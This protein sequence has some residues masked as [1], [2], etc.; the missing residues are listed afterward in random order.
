MLFRYRFFIILR[1]TR[2]CIRQQDGAV[3]FSA[4]NGIIETNWL[5][6]VGY[7][8]RCSTELNNL[9]KALIIGRD[10]FFFV[11]DRRENGMAAQTMAR[12]AMKHHLGHKNGN[13]D[14]IAQ[15]QKTKYSFEAIK[16]KWFVTFDVFLHNNIVV[17][18]D[19]I[20]PISNDSSCV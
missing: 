5:H 4:V 8:F 1:S 6:K 16:C 9:Q 10:L 7:A 13:I 18:N 19:R 20:E 2:H 12:N 11:I 3:S 14:S 15:Q 17:E